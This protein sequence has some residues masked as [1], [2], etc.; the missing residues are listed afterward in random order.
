MAV[1]KKKTPKSSSKVRKSAWVAREQKRIQNVT[2]VT[3]CPETGEAHLSHR[4]SPATG[5]YRGRQ[6]LPPQKIAPE[7]TRIHA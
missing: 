7:K 2:K 5:K 6:V 1:P 4:V 3:H